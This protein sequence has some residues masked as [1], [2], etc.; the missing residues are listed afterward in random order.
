MCAALLGGCC[1][2]LRL[3]G[4]FGTEDDCAEGAEGTEGV[5]G[6]GGKLGLELLGLS[7]PKGGLE[8]AGTLGPGGGLFELPVLNRGAAAVLVVEVAGGG[9]LSSDALFSGAG[10]GGGFERP[11]LEYCEHLSFPRIVV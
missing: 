8:A 11:L 4:L 10:F 6:V 7:L 1:G 2:P 5:E 9:F 3:S